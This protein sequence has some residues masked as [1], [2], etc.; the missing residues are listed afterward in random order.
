MLTIVYRLRELVSET[1]SLEQILR[2][3]DFKALVLL[4]KLLQVTQDLLG[5]PL[6]AILHSRFVSEIKAKRDHREFG[7]TP[8]RR[9]CR[10][11]YVFTISD[12][13]ARRVIRTERQ[14]DD[15]SRAYT[16]VNIRNEIRANNE[17]F[18]HLYKI[19]Q[20]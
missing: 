1:P 11:R 8:P 18:T 19:L 5:C 4:P 3:V 7:M 16:R 6:T 13:A 17:S 20:C 10:A 2:V 14:Q 12:L 15:F 9:C